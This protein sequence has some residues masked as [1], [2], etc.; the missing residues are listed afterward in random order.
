LI[1]E[2]PYVSIITPISGAGIDLSNLRHWLVKT[3]NLPIK[4]VLIHDEVD[5]QV[6]TN[7]E[8]MV[9][10]LSNPY[11][12]LHH[13]KF[14]SPG[15]ARN[16][17]LEYLTTER[18]VFW[19]SDDIGEPHNLIQAIS[20]HR[21]SN[22][23]V[24]SFTINSDLQVFDTQAKSLKGDQNL[25]IQLGMNP[26]IWRYIFKRSVISDTQ[27]STTRMGEDQQF[28]IEIQA[29]P[30]MLSITPL[31]LYNYFVG[32]PNHLTSQYSAKLE[33]I[34]TFNSMQKFFVNRPEK[35]N[36]FEITI[37]LKLLWSTMKYSKRSN[38][39]GTLASFSYLFFISRKIAPSNLIQIVGFVR[40]QR[41][42]HYD[43]NE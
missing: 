23:I 19:D 5:Q 22:V 9:K 28:L 4:T 10:E 43:E 26:G 11:I 12:M 15:A 18:V 13:G 30:K 42:I 41:E 17:G 37:Y 3:Q 16:K 31:I 27:F 34:Q 35:L 25:E 20:D 38:Y 1:Q 24:G 36:L 2:K 32:N 21:D 6:H 33:V 14:G 7:L 39:F 29:I 8:L 40:H